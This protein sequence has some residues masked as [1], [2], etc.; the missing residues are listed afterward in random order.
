VVGKGEDKLISAPGNY[1]AGPGVA[2]GR[3]GLKEGAMTKM[4]RLKRAAREA[5][6]LKGNTLGRFKESVITGER[7]QNQRPGVVASCRICGA[8]AVVDSAPA[9]VKRKSWERQWRCGASR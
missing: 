3:P 4:A 2:R 1:Y 5:A 7:S 6:K 9:R 8:M